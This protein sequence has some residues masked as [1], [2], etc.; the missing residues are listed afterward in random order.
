MFSQEEQQIEIC[1]LKTNLEKIGDDLCAQNSAMPALDAENEQKYRETMAAL[2]VARS[3]NAERERLNLENVKLTAK[4]MQLKR[5]Y[6]LREKANLFRKTSSFYNEDEMR[7]ELEKANNA[8]EELEE[9]MTNRENTVAELKRRLDELQ[10]ETAK[11][12]ALLE[13]RNHLLSSSNQQ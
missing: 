3:L 12:D 7:V 6:S 8:I 13:K 1:L 4:R 11:Y 10:A 5:Q 2:R 9:E